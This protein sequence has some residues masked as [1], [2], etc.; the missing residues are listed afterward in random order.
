MSRLVSIGWEAKNIECIFV[1]VTTCSCVFGLVSDWL[2]SVVCHLNNRKYCS[3]K[4]ALCI[5]EFLYAE[6]KF[7]LSMYNNLKSSLILVFLMYLFTSWWSNYQSNTLFPL[8]DNI[9]S[10]W[11]WSFICN[12]GGSAGH[13]RDKLGIRGPVHLLTGKNKY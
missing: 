3:L 6:S 4:V 11:S 10:G 1:S 2:N 9:G 12:R 13:I 8:S 5:L 7:N